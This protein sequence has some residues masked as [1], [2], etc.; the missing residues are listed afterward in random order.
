MF[1]SNSDS[2]KTINYHLKLINELTNKFGKIT[3]INF[4]KIQNKQENYSIKA[5]NVVNSQYFIP[6]SEKDFI[7]YIKSKKIIAIDCLGKD[8]NFLKLE[9]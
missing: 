4:I 9:H 2:F 7:N 8:L 6:E 1:F 3:F 5:P